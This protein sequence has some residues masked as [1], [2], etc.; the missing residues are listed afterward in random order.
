MVGCF[1]VSCDWLATSSGCQSTCLSKH[2]ILLASS[3]FTKY[4]KLQKSEA[5][6]IAHDVGH[7]SHKETGNSHMQAFSFTGCF[8]DKRLLAVQVT[9]QGRL[10]S[11]LKFKM[12]TWVI[13]I[14]LGFFQPTTTKRQCACKYEL[15]P[16]CTHDPVTVP[17]PK[18][19]G[20][21]VRFNLLK[22]E[23]VIYNQACY[24]KNNLLN[25]ESNTSADLGLHEAKASVSFV[26]TGKAATKGGLYRCEGIVTFPPPLL[27]QRSDVSILVHVASHHCSTG[28][29]K[30]GHGELM[31]WIP[32]LGILCIYSIIITVIALVNWAT[33][34][35]ADFQNDYINTKPRVTSQRRRVRVNTRHHHI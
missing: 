15:Q 20:E 17:C 8:E 31:I 24:Y 3:G 13:V 18:M 34:R 2:N 10:S 9:T 29:T 30:V 27:K 32:V 33:G 16:E 6:L 23:Q 12:R 26:L 4:L 19:A 1:Y 21:E 28:E 5:R 14:M 35:K 25:C 7:R 11:H 22:D